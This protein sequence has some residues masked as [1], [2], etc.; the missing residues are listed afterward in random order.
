MVQRLGCISIRYTSSAPR[1]TAFGLRVCATQV[2]PASRT[3]D[4][5][6]TNFRAS[7]SQCFKVSRAR[8]PLN[9]VV[10]AV[11]SWFAMPGNALATRPFRNTMSANR[12]DCLLLDTHAFRLIRRYLT[13][14]ATV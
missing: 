12:P 4:G 2:R 13:R 8:A 14:N 6:G 10:G 7:Q 11:R 5:A 9:L 3:L 1:L